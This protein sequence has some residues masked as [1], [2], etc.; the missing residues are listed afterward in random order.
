MFAMYTRLTHSKKARHPVLQIVKGVRE[1]KKVKQQ[2]VAS[3]GVIKSKKDLLKLSQLAENLIQKLEQ[4]GLPKD[5]RVRLQDLVHKMTTYDGFGLVVN[6]LLD[7]TGFS[8][9][10]REA[11]GKNSF[12]LEEIIKLIIVQRLDLPSS[13]LRTYERQEEH[14]FYGI[15]LQHVYRAMDV[16]EPLSHDL[17]KKAFETVCAFSKTPVDCFFFDVTTLYF[18]SVS[19]DNLRDFGFSKDQKHHSVQIVLALVV[20]SE[21][22]PIAYETRFRITE[23]SLFHKKYHCCL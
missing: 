3:L 19:Q 7:L 12:D 18:E 13:K 23:K 2:I 1:G 10:I 6:K 5:N 9:V 21:G 4:H 16:I 22:N 20:D 8:K 14:G 11:Q 15:D 17:Q